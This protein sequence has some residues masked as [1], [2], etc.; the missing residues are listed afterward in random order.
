MSTIE[1]VEMNE[2]GNNLLLSSNST[3][4]NS[5]ESLPSISHDDPITQK[6]Q[7]ARKTFAKPLQDVSPSSINNFK[8]I[9]TPPSSSASSPT[10]NN[11]SNDVSDASSSIERQRFRRRLAR[12][13]EVSPSDDDPDDDP[14]P[15]QCNTPKSSVRKRFRS[16]QTPKRR[17][18]LH[19]RTNQHDCSRSPHNF[20]A[21]NT[22][23]QVNG[24]SNHSMLLYNFPADDTEPQVN[25]EISPSRLPQ[26][27]PADNTQDN[28]RYLNPPN[29]NIA[30]DERQEFNESGNEASSGSSGN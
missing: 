17:S 6:A 20:A 9:S 26:N 7:K 18:P 30:Q 10:L 24:R 13:S 19:D 14:E 25:V 11:K 5:Q 3:M 27:F 12:L 21:D 1:N 16:L 22:E 23:P 28:D 4:P 15:S 2:S 8:P 29:Q